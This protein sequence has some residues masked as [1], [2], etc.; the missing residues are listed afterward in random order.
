[1]MA[2]FFFSFPTSALENR[3]WAIEGLRFHARV[4]ARLLP[5][6]VWARAGF[7]LDWYDSRAFVRLGGGFVVCGFGLFILSFIFFDLSPLSGLGYLTFN[8][9]RSFFYFEERFGIQNLGGF[10]LLSLH[11]E[12]F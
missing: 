9:S 8:W 12:M 1:M 2:R 5:F 7:C 10:I 3:S 4:S 11:P 6:T